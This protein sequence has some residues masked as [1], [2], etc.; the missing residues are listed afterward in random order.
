MSG[1]KSTKEKVLHTRVPESLDAQ[2]KALADALRV[3]VSSLVR[4]ILEDS[5]AVID[6][7]KE[8]R[9]GWNEFQ[10][11]IA[12]SFR[13]PQSQHASAASAPAAAATPVP[14]ASATLLFPEVI[15]WQPLTLNISTACA[16]CANALEPG[17]ASHLGVRDVPGSRVL[18]CDACLPRSRASTNGKEVRH[19]QVREYELQVE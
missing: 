16:R 6:S 17:D 14:L 15:G 18:I 12:E 19:D 10:S 3:P 1:T 7:A 5:V 2:I 11:M 13:T 8:L 9:R 4:N